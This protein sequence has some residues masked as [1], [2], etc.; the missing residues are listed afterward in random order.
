V[1]T[2]NSI[3]QQLQDFAFTCDALELEALITRLESVLRF[4][5]DRS[6]RG[7]QI[8]QRLHAAAQE[9]AWNQ[10]YWQEIP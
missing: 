5:R 9:E 10:P 6:Q 7:T 1:T 2:L 8:D 4:A 3:D